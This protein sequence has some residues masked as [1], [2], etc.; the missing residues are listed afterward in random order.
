M[1]ISKGKRYTEEFKIGAVNQTNERG[2][3]VAEVYKQLGIATKTLYHWRS[4]LSD[5]TK[6]VKAPDDEYEPLSK[7]LTVTSCT[8]LEDNKKQR[9]QAI[10]ISF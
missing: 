10:L 1:F 8:Y 2:Y 5:K 6:S 3:S 4:Q 9:C 7:S